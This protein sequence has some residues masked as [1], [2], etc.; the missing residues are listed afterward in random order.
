MKFFKSVL[1]ANVISLAVKL[2]KN[3][4]ILHTSNVISPGS[5]SDETLILENAKVLSHLS[6]TFSMLSACEVSIEL[7]AGNTIRFA[8]MCYLN[9]IMEMLLVK[10]TILQGNAPFLLPP[11]KFYCLRKRTSC[12]SSKCQLI[13]ARIQVL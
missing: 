4:L 8:R 7:I 10:R 6:E 1:C 13:K 11:I 3:F 9:S 5:K 2:D 12:L